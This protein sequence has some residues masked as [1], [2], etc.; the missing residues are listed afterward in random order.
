MARGY[1][2][3]D[4]KPGSPNKST[5]ALKELT[6]CQGSPPQSSRAARHDANRG[7]RVNGLTM[8]VESR[9]FDPS[10]ALGLCLRRREFD[11]LTFEAK[12]IAR[13]HGSKPPQFVDAKA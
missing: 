12:S 8:L 9:P 1:K 4:R 5:K 2:T 3:G 11:H 7:K 6:D 13:A 10:N